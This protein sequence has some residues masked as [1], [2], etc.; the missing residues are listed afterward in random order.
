MRTAS[1]TGVLFGSLVLMAG[2]VGNGVARPGQDEDPLEITSRRVGSGIL[3]EA[4]ERGGHDRSV[5]SVLRQRVAGFRISS[6]SSCPEIVIRGRNSVRSS[7]N[8]SIFVNDTRSSDT[9]VLDDLRMSDIDRVEVYPTG[10][11]PNPSYGT[12][13]NGLILVFTRRDRL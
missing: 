7:P 3:I 13:S 5:L 12:N 9:C 6:T 4:A 2:C 10:V 1:G 8:P 11:G